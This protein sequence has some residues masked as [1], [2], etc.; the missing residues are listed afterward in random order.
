MTFI[1]FSQKIALPCCFMAYEPKNANNFWRTMV[2]HGSK[3]VAGAR[4]ISRLNPSCVLYFTSGAQLRQWLCTIKFFNPYWIPFHLAYMAGE[5][6]KLTVPFKSKTQSGIVFI[7]NVLNTARVVWG[8]KKVSVN[9]APIL[10]FSPILNT[11]GPNDQVKPVT[12]GFPTNREC[13]IW[14]LQ[15]D[16]RRR[17][18]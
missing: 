18:I 14:I 11:A 13:L 16:G 5:V 9:L 8:K 15:N 6:G 10:I 4:V 12:D 2:L 1:T 3:S 17:L 7:F